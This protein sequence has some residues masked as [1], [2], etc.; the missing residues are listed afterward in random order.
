MLVS[1]QAFY[2]DSMAILDFLEQERFREDASYRFAL[3]LQN[4][5]NWLSLFAMPLKTRIQYCSE[6]AAAFAKEF[7]KATSRQIDQQYRLHEAALSAMAL[8][9]RDNLQILFNRNKALEALELP[10][11][12][13]SSYIHMSI[14]RWFNSNQRLL[15]YMA[16][17]YSEKRYKQALSLSIC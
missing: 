11:E 3:A 5:D 14:N 7:D 4:I 17:R 2:F 1:E 16:Y 12:N 9:S 10:F 8:E 13:I 15:E 6:M